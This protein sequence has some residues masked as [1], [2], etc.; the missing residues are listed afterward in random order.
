MEVWSKEEICRWENLTQTLLMEGAEANMRLRRCLR[1]LRSINADKVSRYCWEIILLISTSVQRNISD[2]R[3]SSFQN[4]SQY[5]WHHIL[6]FA[7]QGSH[8]VQLLSEDMLM[9]SSSIERFKATHFGED[10]RINTTILTC[11]LTDSRSHIL[12]YLAVTI[13]HWI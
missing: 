4:F 6:P 13:T 7:L 1:P 11:Q 8:L 2:S 9:S 5:Q 12:S 3:Q 10:T